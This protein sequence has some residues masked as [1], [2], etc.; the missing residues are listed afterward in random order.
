MR[1]VYEVEPLFRALFATPAGRELHR[2]TAP[3]RRQAIDDMLVAELAELTPQQRRRFVAVAH[4]LSS[5]RSVL[6]LKDYHDLDADDAVAAI[7]WA[8]AALVAAV[9]D[10]RVERRTCDRVAGARRRHVAAGDDARAGRPAPGLP[11]AGDHGLRRRLRRPAAAATGC[12]STTSRCASSTTTATAGWCPSAPPSRSRASRARHRRPSSCGCSPDSTPSCVDG[13][14]RRG[15]R[16]DEKAVAR[17]PA[18]GG[19]PSSDRRDAR[20]QPGAC[21]PSDLEQLD[22]DALVDHLAGPP[23]T[24]SAA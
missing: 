13:R 7:R 3:Q 20:R 6:L 11:G 1:A 23:T 19:R 4:L 14:R 16:I 5:S 9:R 12:R 8:L 15:G 10:P 22:D 18:G 24:S 21:R 2:R 17:G